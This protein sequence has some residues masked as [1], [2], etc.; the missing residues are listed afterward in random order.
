MSKHDE[1]REAFT[2]GSII[3]LQGQAKGLAGKSGPGGKS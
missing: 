1:A 3:G 2:R